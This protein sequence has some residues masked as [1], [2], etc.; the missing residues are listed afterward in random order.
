MIFLRTHPFLDSFIVLGTQFWP[1]RHF[2]GSAILAELAEKVLNNERCKVQMRAHLFL[3]AAK[4]RRSISD[5][6]HHHH[7]HQRTK[8]KKFAPGGLKLHKNNKYDPSKVIRIKL[9]YHRC[10]IKAMGKL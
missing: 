10:L 8:F 7:H 6:I 1:S 4:P 5:A 9:V 3:P 2:F